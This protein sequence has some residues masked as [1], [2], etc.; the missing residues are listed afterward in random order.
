MRKDHAFSER[1]VCR[2]VQLA[3]S[4]FRYCLSRDDDLRERLQTLARERPRFG[5]RRLHALGD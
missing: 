2:L 1:R 3:A 5:Y 4:T